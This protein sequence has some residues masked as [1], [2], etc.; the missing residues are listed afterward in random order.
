MKLS[1]VITLAPIPRGADMNDKTTHL[2][3][4]DGYDLERQKNGDVTVGKGG[5]F[6]GFIG[7]CNVAY[8]APLPESATKAA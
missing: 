3:A 1:L 5:K 4:R 2:L 8:G 7:A 6:V